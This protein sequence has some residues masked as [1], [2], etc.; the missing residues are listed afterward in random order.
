MGLYS[1]LQIHEG[2]NREVCPKGVADRVNLGLIP[3]A[4]SSYSAAVA[5]LRQDAG[6]VLHIHG[7]VKWEQEQEGKMETEATS[8][9]VR[10][11]PEF[12]CKHPEWRAWALETA[13]RIRSLWEESSSS[14]EAKVTMLLVTK[15]KSYAPRVDH[16]VLDLK[17]S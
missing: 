14:P 3:T 11:G 17:C 10:Q 15:I 8:T 7:N 12:S 4:A 9:T 13:E 16:L 6:G 2:D 1:S 5:A